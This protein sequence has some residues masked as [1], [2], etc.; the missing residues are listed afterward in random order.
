MRGAPDSPPSPTVASLLPPHSTF[1]RKL[2][3]QCRKRV[4]IRGIFHFNPQFPECRRCVSPR[5]VGVLTGRFIHVYIIRQPRPL[6]K[7][8]L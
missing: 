3:A 6:D 4:I 1:P 8:S 7:R 5:V 2:L